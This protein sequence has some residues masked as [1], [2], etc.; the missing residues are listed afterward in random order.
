MQIDFVTLCLFAIIILAVLALIPRLMGG[1]GRR[2]DYSQR[3]DEQPYVDDPNISGGGAFGGRPDGGYG[4]ERPS[5]DD[6][7]VSGRGGFGRDRPNEPRDR[8]Q[9]SYGSSSRSGGGFFSNPFAGRSSSGGKPNLTKGGG[10]R[11]SG[12]FGRNKK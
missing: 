4:D 7:N 5:Y 11:S 12:G 6:P 8:E 10:S 3:G 1:G 9:H 2:V